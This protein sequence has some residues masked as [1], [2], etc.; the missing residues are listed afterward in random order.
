M[1]VASGGEWR[2]VPGLRRSAVLAALALLQGDS[3]SVDRLVDVVWGDRPPRTA[4]D[5]VRNHLSYLRRILPEGAAVVARPAGYA[6]ELSGGG[7][8]VQVAEDL[9]GQAI[10]STDVRQREDRLRTA[11]ALWQGPP[12][13]DLTDMVWFDSHAQR[14]RRLLLQARRLLIDARLELGEHRYLVS[15][16]EEL[17]R[18]HPL[19]EQLHG[20]L[21]TALYRSG[22]QADALEAY[23]RLR[24]TLDEQLG[25]LPDIALRD[26]ET[27][28]LR[29]DPAL[30][31]PPTPAAVAATSPPA[32]APVRATVPAKLDALDFQLI[33]TLQIEPR[34]DW[35]RIGHVLGVTPGTAARRWARMTEA[36]MAW[37]S[38][39][40]MRI[41]EATPMVSVIEI[42]CVAGQTQA[43][44]A[45]IAQDPHIF[46]ANIVTGSRDI[47]IIAA[48]SDRD[49][50]TRYLDN[51]LGVLPGVKATRSSLAGA[52]HSEGSRWRLDRLEA[53][54]L[55]GLRPHRTDNVGA[56]PLDPADMDII[57]ALAKDCRRPIAEVAE[58]TNLSPSTV[59]R[60]LSRLESDRSVAYR[61]DV[62]QADFGWPI[63]VCLW[64]D[65]AAEHLPRV[66]AQLSG[67]REVRFCATLTGPNNLMFG[68][69]FRNIEDCSDLEARVRRQIPE[70][71][72]TDRAVTLRS[73]K[74]GGNVLDP[75]GRLIRRVP[76]APWQHDMPGRRP[77]LSI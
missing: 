2:A 51:R 5:T 39:H 52:L 6:L 64:A 20:W 18:E 28:I 11:I 69:W 7:V 50:L 45:E 77:Q 48:F 27:A 12:L 30:A 72:I 47:L 55:A 3:V 66:A 10:R 74:I 1:T 36:G 75:Q 40:P 41:P 42:E 62:A 14:L 63:E 49:S 15:E 46:T 38:C 37:L 9:I 53:R 24:I 67:M 4:S 56:R 17:T 31:P 13:G 43:V 61:C 54:R 58:I 25:V 70:L 32:T 19:D 65:I 68:A 8:D 29:Q 22:R 21:M 26:L 16:L 76:I 59:N 23:H 71:V 34:A 33:T 60:R 73:Y 57:T 44:A 35:Q